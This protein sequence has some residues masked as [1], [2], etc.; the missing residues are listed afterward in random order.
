MT[1]LPLKRNFQ[2][3]PWLWSAHWVSS[4]CGKRDVSS[5]VAWMWWT[6]AWCKAGLVPS[7]HHGPLWE[8]NRCL[9]RLQSNANLIIKWISVGFQ[10]PPYFVMF[11]G[12]RSSNLNIHIFPCSVKQPVWAAPIPTT[13]HTWILSSCSTSTITGPSTHNS[14]N[15]YR[16]SPF[17]SS[18]SMFPFRPT[19]YIVIF[20]MRTVSFKTPS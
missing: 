17:T 18:Q 2:T 3:L 11:K 15:L 19:T 1:H 13:I 5:A 8:A 4:K 6:L 12:I 14:P 16:P 9:D 7:K 10:M 20:Y